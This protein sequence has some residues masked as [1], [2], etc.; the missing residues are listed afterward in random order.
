MTISSSLIR[1]KKKKNMR[2]T[3]QINVLNEMV[4]IVA[5]VVVGWGKK[6]NRVVITQPRPGDIYL[7]ETFVF[8]WSPRLEIKNK[9]KIESKRQRVGRNKVRCRGYSSRKNLKK[10]LPDFSSI[11]A[12]V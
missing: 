7:S 1:M 9:C 6:G 3:R 2:E 4:W 11:A 10:V 8:S 5:V 12:A